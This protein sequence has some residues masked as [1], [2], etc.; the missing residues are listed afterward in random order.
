MSDKVYDLSQL[1]E[2]AGGSQ[3]FVMSMVETFLEHTPGQLEELKA[4]FN[5]GDLSA[6]GGVA[7]KIKP[8][9]DLFGVSSIK[10]EIRL[11]ESL[12]KEQVNA[13][14]LSSKIDKIDSVLQLS[15]QQLAAHKNG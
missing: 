14:E 1:E 2:L 9:I 7:H 11:V 6:M 4:A 5:S 8:N 10:E 12:G 13:P 3:E 15:F